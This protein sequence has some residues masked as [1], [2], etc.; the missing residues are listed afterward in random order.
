MAPL[1]ALVL[2]CLAAGASAVIRVP[3]EKR[4]YDPSTRLG[5][6]RRGAVNGLSAEHVVS[7]VDFMDAQAR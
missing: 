4:P 7:L 3:L 6:L 2:A 1:R 5:G